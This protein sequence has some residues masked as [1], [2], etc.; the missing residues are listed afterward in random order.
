VRERVAVAGRLKSIYWGCRPEAENALDFN[1]A[2]L[3]ETISAAIPGRES[4]V[5]RDRRL[6]WS[7]LTE[8]TRRLANHLRDE[9]LRVH[10]ERSE[11][12]DWESGQDS[13]GLYLHNG[14]EY[15]EAMLG[16]FKARV[17]P[18]NLNYRFVESELIQVLGD[19]GARGLVFHSCFATRVEKVVAALPE[20]RVL[21]QVED[22]SNA[23]LVAGA[24]WY[25][26]ALAAASNERPDL[27]WSPDDLYV[28]Y[29]G[30]TTGLPKGVLWR[31]AD[32]FPANMNGRRDDGSLFGSLEEI[33]ERARTSEIRVL[34]QAPF[35]HVT[36][37]AAALGMW[38]AGG[39]V[40]IPDVVER[41]EA[42]SI[43]A[44]MAHE[45]VN[46]SVL[47]GDAMA[48]PLVAAIREGAHVPE[49]LRMIV[50]GGAAMNPRTKAELL[51]LL[52]NVAI[53]E[54]LGS[55]ET[56]G[57]AF[58]LSS[59]AGGVAGGGFDAGP[60]TTILDETRERV[61]AGDEFS[62]G[63][64]ARSG[65][66]PLGYLGDAE[67]TRTTFPRVGGTRYVVPGDRA[68]WKG[69]GG[70]EFL[71]RDSTKINSAGEKIYAEEVELVLKE[72]PAVLDAAVAGR[73][74]ERWGEEVVAVVQLQPSRETSAE[75]ILEACKDRLARFKHPKVILFRN[76]I[77][78]G[79][80][81]KLDLGWLRRE[82]AA[83]ASER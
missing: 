38:N 58:N 51:E 30:G 52:P 20:L 10:R 59:A 73:P 77:R 4:L 29:T 63:W 8:R 35:M 62:I 42:H 32:I 83:E 43:L 56:G 6:T 19:A 76:E 27:E 15:L 7:Q 18:L 79:A 22:G 80:A 5:F 57:Q 70:F 68:R 40:V 1:L 28:T 11:L 16:S 17:V 9:G 64:L 78:R 75:E 37:H 36:G 47:V 46:V 3:H 31:Q 13:V 54:G 34:P 67:K 48:R 33:V 44:C 69:D 49:E 55:S 61:L 65:P 12:A 50:S 23:P 25:E 71:G 2:Q 82:I 24:R 45:R 21:L 14:N 72:H 39:T 41:F 53:V 74:S 81:G 26:E 66:I 60:G